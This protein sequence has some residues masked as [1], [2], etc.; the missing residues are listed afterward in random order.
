MSY[1][2]FC[3]KMISKTMRP[4]VRANPHRAGVG[5]EC[6]RERL[7][8]RVLWTAG[9]TLIELLVVLVIVVAVSTLI[10]TSVISA[11]KQQNQRTCQTNMLTIEAAKDEFVRDHPGATSIPNIA[12]FQPYFR[13]GITLCQDNGDYQNLLNLTE[14]VWCSVHGRIQ[15]NSSPTP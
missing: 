1:E 15:T 3:S 9:L 14:P 11:L 4:T 7:G 12:T 2:T 10:T 5:H 6:M 13:F 8:L